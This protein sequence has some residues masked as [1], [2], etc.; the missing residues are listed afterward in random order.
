MYLNSS[1]IWRG[2]ALTP[3]LSR[4][5]CISACCVFLP[6]KSWVWRPTISGGKGSKSKGFAMVSCTCSSTWCVKMFSPIIALLSWMG[7]ANAF[8]ADCASL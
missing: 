5:C 3:A 1:S 2:E 6:M 4:S 7:M 8:S